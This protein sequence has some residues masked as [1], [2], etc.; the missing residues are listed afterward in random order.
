MGIHELMRIVAARGASTY[1]AWRN[2]CCAQYRLWRVTLKLTRWFAPLGPGHRLVWRQGSA[3]HPTI[4]ITTTD[5]QY[6][7]KCDFAGTYRRPVGH[8][9]VDTAS[10]RIRHGDTQISTAEAGTRCV[11]SHCGDMILPAFRNDVGCRT[12]AQVW[13]VTGLRRWL[14]A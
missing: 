10:S 4:G 11:H 14:S 2:R 13:G 12:C 9:D 5:V 7:P 8:G 1:S 6:D 3:G